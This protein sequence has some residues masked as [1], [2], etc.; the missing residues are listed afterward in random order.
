MKPFKLQNLLPRRIQGLQLLKMLPFV[1]PRHRLRFRNLTTMTPFPKRNVK[2]ILVQEGN[3]SLKLLG[4]STLF[5]RRSF[6]TS[7][8]KPGLIP[9]LEAPHSSLAQHRGHVSYVAE[10]LKTH[11][12]LKINLGF[13]DSSSRYLQQLCLS[14][15]EN[16]GH[17]LPITHSGTRGWFV[18]V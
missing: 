18:G 4:I 7:V 6:A 15:H 1:T 8:R 14:L 5:K 16:C 13:P 17:Q 3:I 12:V 11:G 2:G 10:Q 9:S